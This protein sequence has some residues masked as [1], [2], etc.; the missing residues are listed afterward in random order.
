M[1]RCPAQYQRPGGRELGDRIVECHLVDCHAGDHEEAGT[2]FAWSDPPPADPSGHDIPEQVYLDAARARVL[3]D[4]GGTIGPWNPEW[5][6]QM[7]QVE[8]E[9][10]ENRAA[11]ESAYRAGQAAGADEVEPLPSFGQLVDRRRMMRA[12]ASDALSE[13]ERAVVEA[14]KAWRAARPGPRVAG[15]DVEFHL[16]AAVDALTD[17]TPAAGQD[18]WPYG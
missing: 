1:T 13:P 12:T 10:P 3:S 14:A 7:I 4:I 6:E 16:F 17:A 8:A 5:V 11:V 18:G 9:R 15:S 2:G